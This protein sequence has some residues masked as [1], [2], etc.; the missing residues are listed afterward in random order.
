MAEA[1]L[2]SE[3]ALETSS[4]SSSSF[5]GGGGRIL[6]TPSGADESP[7]MLTA[8]SNDF[9]EGTSNI[10]PQQ[11]QL[12]QQRGRAM[13]AAPPST[14]NGEGMQQQ[15][16]QQL[17]SRS[18][19]ASRPS[20]LSAV[21]RRGSIAGR[22]GAHHSSA[23]PSQSPPRKASHSPPPPRL[24]AKSSPAEPLKEELNQATVEEK[25]EED[26]SPA[27]AEFTRTNSVT[28]P[29]KEQSRSN[30]APPRRPYALSPVT[31][32]TSGEEL[33]PPADVS[34][35][36]ASQPKADTTTGRRPSF[37]SGPAVRGASLTNNSGTSNRRDPLAASSNRPSQSPAR[38]NLNSPRSH[39]SPRISNSLPRPRAK[40]SGGGVDSE[41]LPD[42]KQQ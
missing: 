24:R 23:R 37:S 11:Q 5:S 18:I 6:R 33:T 26:L 3:H 25:E 13:S 30:T 28:R 36:D 2:Q 40:P 42:A 21:G 8:H 31:V 39:S 19:Y 12:P 32:T 7:P 27:A 14:L 38:P 4:S 35:A 10:H 41:P 15:R 16:Q 22:G 34:P 29:S 20:D 9:L 1:S 17:P